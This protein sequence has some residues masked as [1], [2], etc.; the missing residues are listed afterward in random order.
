MTTSWRTLPED[1]TRAIGEEFTVRQDAR[2]LLRAASPNDARRLYAYALDRNLDRDGRLLRAL[3]EDAAL[4]GLW[5]QVLGWVHAETLAVSAAA[6]S[7]D[8]DPGGASADGRWRYRLTR[9]QEAPFELVLII[10]LTGDGKAPGRLLARSPRHGT[11]DI[12]LEPPHRGI[13][14]MIF[15]HADPIGDV[16]GDPDRTV[17]MW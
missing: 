7:G 1:S 3:K 11:V 12:E 4:W 8:N 13:I 6:A 14:Q 2:A 16:L 10:E 5:Q 17:S 9:A 15:D